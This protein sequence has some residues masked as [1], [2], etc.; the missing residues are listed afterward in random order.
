[1]EEFAEPQEHCAISSEF[2]VVSLTSFQHLTHLTTLRTAEAAAA[3]VVGV[4][5][6]RAGVHSWCARLMAGLG[7]YLGAWA[8]T[9]A[10]VPSSRTQ[11]A[12]LASPS[13]LPTAA[14]STPHRGWP[15]EHGRHRRVPPPDQGQRPACCCDLGHR[16]WCRRRGSRRR[17]H[18]CYCR[19]CFRN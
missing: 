15:P 19:C 5:C 1:M 17:C 8:Q 11:P 12:A 6:V 18:G 10:A 9:T 2:R 3:C 14:R 7:F 16:C 13:A 4:R